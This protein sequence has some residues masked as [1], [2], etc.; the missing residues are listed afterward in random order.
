MFILILSTPCINFVLVCVQ[1]QLEAGPP[2]GRAHPSPSPRHQIMSTEAI[3][4]LEFDQTVP[5]SLSE[6]FIA[7]LEQD[8]TGDGSDCFNEYQHHQMVVS[9]NQCRGIPVQQQASYP[10]SSP[11]NGDFRKYPSAEMLRGSYSNL[12]SASLSSSA[13]ASPSLSA[14]SS[15]GGNESRDFFSVEDCDASVETGRTVEAAMLEADANGFDVFSGDEKLQELAKLPL[16]ILESSIKFADSFEKGI[17]GRIEREETQASVAVG[18]MEGRRGEG[19]G[20]LLSI[21]APGDSI[22]RTVSSNSGGSTDNL[23]P[24]SMLP[25]QTT[26]KLAGRLASTEAA[27]AETSSLVP[28]VPGSR[29][30]SYS[31]DDI[32]SIT[33]IENFLLGVSDSPVICPTSGGSERLV[34][35]IEIPAMHLDLPNNFEKRTEVN[36]SSSSVLSNQMEQAKRTQEMLS[37]TITVSLP[38]PEEP[39]DSVRNRNRSGSLDYMG[40]SPLGDSFKQ[41]PSYDEYIKAHNSNTTVI[42][43]S[44]T[45]GCTDTH[46]ENDTS[47]SA[48]VAMETSNSVKSLAKSGADDHAPSNLLDDIMECIQ[49]EAGADDMSDDSQLGKTSW[50]HRHTQS[51]YR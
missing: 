50:N 35:N 15:A 32:G 49:L 4:H 47:T 12:T 30:K 1:I 16:S 5:S 41:P 45:L 44:P 9:R 10:A 40:S 7:M 23:T 43:P 24:R 33:S 48:G 51:T 27:E 11:C 46:A 18:E 14:P 29:P 31:M 21:P 28:P 36:N 26:E 22:G 39:E 13:A 42:L 6:E 17:L 25:G 19:G 34:E 20:S 3:F 8:F 37:P 38:F 2:L